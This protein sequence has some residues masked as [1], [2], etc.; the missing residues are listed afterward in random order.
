AGGTKPDTRAT[1]DGNG[2]GPGVCLPAVSAD[3]KGRQKGAA[4]SASHRDRRS[5]GQG[6]G[7]APRRGL[8]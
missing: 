6:S 4:C 8:G 1:S 7:D 3:S 2:S 5:I